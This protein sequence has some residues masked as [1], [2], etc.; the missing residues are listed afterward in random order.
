MLNK[1]F[2]LFSNFFQVFSFHSFKPESLYS[3]HISLQIALNLAL[4][5]EICDK[6]AT[7]CDKQ[8]L[9]DWGMQYM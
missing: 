5:A 6:N 1:L 4:H 3:A 8:V 7:L 9:S 2:S